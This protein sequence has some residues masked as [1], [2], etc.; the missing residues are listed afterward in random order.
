[1]NRPGLLQ[2]TSFSVR[3]FD[4]VSELEYY[5]YLFL[6]SLTEFEFVC[7]KMSLQELIK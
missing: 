6:I 5:F 1:M 7:V 4:K 2:L 3:Q